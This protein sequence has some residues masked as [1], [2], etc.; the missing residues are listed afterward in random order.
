MKLKR[1]LSFFLLTFLLTLGVS[2]AIGSIYAGF[3]AM[4]NTIISKPLLITGYIGASLVVGLAS[5]PKKLNR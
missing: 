2:V 5:I 3:D 4:I 1:F